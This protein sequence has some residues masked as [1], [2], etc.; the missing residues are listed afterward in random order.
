MHGYGYYEYVDGTKYK[1]QF[2]MDKKQGFGEY[3]WQ[4][5]RS[6]TGYWVNGK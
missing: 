5:N 1:G 6:Y 4:N 3:T 2:Y